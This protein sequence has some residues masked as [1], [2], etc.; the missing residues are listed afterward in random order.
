M[1]PLHF[2]ESIGSGN[3]L[4]LSGN[5]LLPEPNIGILAQIY[6]T[7]SSHYATMG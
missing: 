3:G 6:V 5:N 2:Q 7:I 1:L 4:V